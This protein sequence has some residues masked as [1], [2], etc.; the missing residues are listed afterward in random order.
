MLSGPVGC[1]V[2]VGHFL[3][4]RCAGFFVACC[5]DLDHLLNHCLDHLIE[6]RE[7]ALYC[8]VLAQV[9]VLYVQSNNSSILLMYV[10]TVE[11]RFIGNVVVVVVVAHFI[12]VELSATFFWKSH[13]CCDC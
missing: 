3:F 9:S 13:G 11:A 2:I 4:E 10:L 5:E 7:H 1:G 6:L 8:T 12:F